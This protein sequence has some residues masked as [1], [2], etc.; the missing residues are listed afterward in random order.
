MRTELDDL[1]AI[2]N[3]LG[4][5]VN[6]VVLTVVARA[7]RRDLDRR[8]FPIDGLELKVFVPISMRG[9]DQRGQTGNMV[10]GMVV[11]LPVSLDDPVEVP[12][13]D[14]RVHA[15]SSRTPARRWER[16]R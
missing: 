1:K 2:K 13:A 10:S 7:L 6:D 15:A 5:T 11:A 14:R 9:D 8:A 3:A 12:P 4:G 16:R